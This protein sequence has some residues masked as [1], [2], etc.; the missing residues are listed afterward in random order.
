MDYRQLVRMLAAGR[1]VVG[2]ALVVLP[3]VAGS[4]WVGPTAHEAETKVFAR[5]LGVRDLA[6]GLGT[7]NA[8]DKGEPVRS[9]VQLGGLSDA[10]D[11]AA[12]AIALRRIG[13]RRAL[14]LM[15][16]AATAA[17]LSVLAQNELD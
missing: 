15:V 4:Q 7:L 12:T 6:L 17:T 10:V 9:W 11:F 13:A 14:P 8:L 16:V 3:G 5:A 2:A 1:V